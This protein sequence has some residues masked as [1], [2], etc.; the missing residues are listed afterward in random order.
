MYLTQ[1]KFFPTSGTLWAVASLPDSP[2]KG[3][4]PLFFKAS[5]IATLHN[6]FINGLDICLSL[7][8]ISGKG[9]VDCVQRMGDLYRV[10]TKTWNARED[11][12]IKGFCFNGVSVTLLSRNPFRTR[13]QQV[14][15]TKLI[16]GG[17][18][19]SVA[20]S[21]I[22]RSLLDLNLNLLSDIKYETYRDSEGKWTHFKTGRRFVYIE[23]PQLNLNQF[24]QIG[25]W[26]AS[27]FYKEQIRPN[28]NNNEQR[29]DNTPDGTTKTSAAVSTNNNNNTA[30]SRPQRPPRTTVDTARGEN[31]TKPTKGKPT[32]SLFASKSDTIKRNEASGEGVTSPV[33][34]VRSADRSRGRSPTRRDR[35]NKLSSHWS[36]LSFRS[37]SAKRKVG[38]SDSNFTELNK[39]I[40]RIFI[41]SWWRRRWICF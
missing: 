17:V 23:I 21:E 11:L 31:Q 37:S 28:K 18:P 10:Y 5:T 14:K 16:I 41:S 27:L 13:D 12:L 7:E 22:E 3:I 20:D 40:N 26:R 1:K 34:T 36:P 24:L 6:G 15:S 8:E 35:R 39:T 38:E 29:T 4:T 32:Y 9:T 2:T 33:K 30:V 19:M 25:L